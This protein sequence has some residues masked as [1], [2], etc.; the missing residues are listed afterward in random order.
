MTTIDDIKARIDL[1]DYVGQFVPLK[2]S[3]KYLKA[4]CPFHAEKTP[5]FMLD[6]VRQSWRCFGACAEGGDLFSFAMKRHGWSFSEALVELA[7]LAGVELKPRSADQIR[8]DEHLDR[9]RGLLAAAAESYHKCLLE[10]EGADHARRYA[11]QRGLNS[12]TL[13]A[14]DIGYAPTANAMIRHLTGIGYSE[15]DVYQSGIANRNERGQLYD[16]MRD[17]LIFP[18][19]DERGR[20]VAFAGRAL[21]NDVKPKYLNTRETPLFS[22]SRTLFGYEREALRESETAVVV[23][24]YM[25]VITAHQAGYRNVVAQMGTALTAAHVKLLTP[26]KRIVLA[27]DGDAAGQQATRHALEQAIRSSRDVRILALP[28]GQDPDDVIRQTPERWSGLVERAVPVADY[29]IAL[30]TAGIDPDGGLPERRDLA[31]RILPL[32]L[33]TQESLYQQDNLRK[34]AD[35]LHLPEGELM[36][37]AQIDNP[38]VLVAPPKPPTRAP[39]EASCI[40]AILQTPGWYWELVG[41]MGKLKLEPLSPD[42]FTD[43]RPIFEQFLASLDQEALTSAEFVEDAV[44]ELPDTPEQ[45]SYRDFVQQAFRLRVRRLAAEI[46]QMLAQQIDS[47]RIRP[48]LREKALLQTRLLEQH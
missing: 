22:K 42:D 45:M 34:L 1:G 35:R 6:P 10:Y 41:M 39:V 3:G 20:A 19:R 31:K 30:E 24:G 38:P 37:L 48:R 16:A 46:D 26:A 5:S 4:C 21:H 23:E 13:A 40:A 28:E 43:Y 2:K 9:L 27:L 32:L 47:A 29:V 15:D 17:R 8:R 25:D 12:D 33:A 7:K 18:I 11:E 14:W 44:G 36:L